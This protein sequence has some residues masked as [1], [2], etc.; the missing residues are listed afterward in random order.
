MK[1]LLL[2]LLVA[3]FCYQTVCT[4]QLSASKTLPTEDNRIWAPVTLTRTES[5]LFPGSKNIAVKIAANSISTSSIAPFTYCKGSSVSVPFTVS[6]TFNGDNVFTAQIS[7]PSGTFTNP[8][9]I[10]TLT[11]TIDGTISGTIP[12][13]IANSGTYRIRVISSSPAVNGT[14]NG[15]NLTVN[16]LPA[17]Y[18][19][20]GSSSYCAEGNGVVIG[21]SNSEIG[22]KY[23]LKRDGANVGS[24]QNGNFLPISFGP[25]KTVGTYT[26]VA[27]FTATG[28]SQK[29]A[30]SINLTINPLP[31]QFNVT[32]G[33]SY[34]AGGSGNLVG[35]SSSQPGV[36]Y[37]LL[38]Y[39]TE[40]GSPIGGTGDPLSFGNQTVGGLYTII[41]KN[42]QTGCSIEMSG[43]ANVV[44]NPLPNQYDVVGGGTYCEG[45]NGVA[46]LLYSS[47]TNVVYQLKVDGAN[48]GAPKN[49]TGLAIEFGLQKLPG[50]YTVEA[51]NTK[52][53]CK[54]MMTGSKT[55]IRTP[56]PA[57]PV[58]TKIGNDLSSSA[59][60]GNQWYIDQQVILGANS[61]TYSPVASGKYSVIVTDKGCTSLMSDLMDVTINSSKLSAGF[62]AAPTT[63]I[64]PLLVVFTDA[65]TGKPK[66]WNWDFGDSQTSTE[67]NPSHTYTKAGSYTVTLVVSDGTTNDTKTKVAFIVVEEQSEV[68]ANFSATVTGGKAPL[69]VKFTDLSTGSPTAWEW[70][71]GDESA[72]STVNNPE[73]TYNTVGKYSV[74]LTV[75]KDSKQYKTTKKDFITIENASNAPDEGFKSGDMTNKHFTLIPNPNDGIGS[76]NYYSPQVQNI[77]LTM[78]SILGKQ[79]L[80]KEL[81]MQNGENTIPLDVTGLDV[82]EGMY[83]ITIQHSGGTISRIMQIVK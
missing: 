17:L 56:I 2:P 69:L 76:I 61:K 33:G 16:P 11:G 36:S 59:N 30:D 21:V 49:G 66:T 6:G 79:I 72:F 34:C 80:R 43:N 73:H 68:A 53:T 24:E 63:G 65:S 39:S 70:D 4:A 15:T 64:A 58:I 74:T 45:D 38:R 40:T 77:T 26:V 10:G 19:I 52:T 20:T 13:T 62:N 32:G 25:Q 7:D 75:T 47:D 67:Q 78:T 12:L 82:A 54:S 18:S 71:F 29:M 50:V 27:T 9:T 41:G 8:T 31:Q 37:Q 28:C 3:L 35:L 81:V 83:Y 14:D 46:V 48:T 44:V 5:V 1:K 42:L 57:K 51:T 22:V 60:T 23:Q 55:V